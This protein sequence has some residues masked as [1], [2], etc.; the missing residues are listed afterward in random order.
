MAGPPELTHADLLLCTWPRFLSSGMAEE[1]IAA[2][3][4]P[5][6]APSGVPLGGIGGGASI[7]AVTGA[8]ATSA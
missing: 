6:W 8:F 7:S 3:D 4:D 1:W 2:Q 5:L